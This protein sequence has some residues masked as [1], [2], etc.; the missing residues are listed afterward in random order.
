M[1]WLARQAGGTFAGCIAWLKALPASRN[2]A[3][4]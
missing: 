1:R 2:P 4:L 3:D